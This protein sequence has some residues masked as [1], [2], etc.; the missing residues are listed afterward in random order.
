MG[1]KPSIYSEITIDKDGKSVDMRLAVAS[2]VFF[3]DILTPALTCKIQIA[4]IGGSTKLKGSGEALSL[5]EGMKIRGGEEVRIF[6]Q[7]NSD[8]TEGISLLD[9]PLYVNSI[10]NV[11]REGNKEFFVLN[12]VSRAGFENE[13]K[14]VQKSYSKEA[15]ISDHVQSILGEFFPLENSEI[16]TTANTHGF[17]GNQRKPFEL[18][19]N[20]ASKAVSGESGSSDTAA[21]YLFYYTR[22]GFF[23]K[24]IARMV[25]EPSKASFYYDETA[26]N[27]L[28]GGNIDFRIIKYEVSKNQSV[29]NDLRKGAYS[30]SR[31][32]FDPV[33]FN[34]T[35]E[36]AS[37]TGNNYENKMD[38]L[39]NPFSPDDRALANASISFDNLPSRILTETLDRGTVEKDVSIEQ[40]KYIDSY[41]AQR[42][43]RY[44]SLFSQVITIQV[45]STTTIYAG[46]IVECYLPKMN[47]DDHAREYDYEQVGGRYMVK[48]ISHYF[49]TR[50]SYT[51][52]KLI[53]DSFGFDTTK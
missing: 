28:S 34:V 42:K 3:E 45:P 12:L 35:G 4:D 20:L 18:L 47:G 51:N 46:D 32:F 44:N 21:G 31:R 36:E 53:R 16:D 39:N 14:F 17:I 40:T 30:S 15:R 11:I 23:F 48:E 52:M 6:I 22:K 50:G 41:L 7:P 13:F 43:V 5:Y 26:E 38:T 2:I 9:T 25:N 33:T 27:E 1:I 19:I 37:Y 49:D 24:S 10:K 29:I 8:S